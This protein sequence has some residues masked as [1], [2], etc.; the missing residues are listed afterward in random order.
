MIVNFARAVNQFLPDPEKQAI[1]FSKT[2]KRN[3]LHVESEIKKSSVDATMEIGRQPPKFI[4]TCRKNQS[5]YDRE[6]Q[7]FDQAHKLVSDLARA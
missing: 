7:L 1:H 2:L 4:G 3:L 6:R 5:R